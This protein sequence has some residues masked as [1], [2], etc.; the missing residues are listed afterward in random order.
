MP[1]IREITEC[2]KCESDDLTLTYNR[3]A[4]RIDVECNECGFTISVE[5]ADK[6]TGEK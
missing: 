3:V 6:A 1:N 5:P 4:D 2:P